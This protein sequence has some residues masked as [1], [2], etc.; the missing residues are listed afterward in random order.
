MH[1]PRF[2]RL[3]RRDA[4]CFQMPCGQGALHESN[5][6]LPPPLYGRELCRRLKGDAATQSIPIIL[7][8]AAGRNA[9]GDVGADD[10][11]DKP[12]DLANLPEMITR[13]AK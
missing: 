2:L 13:W 3:Y 8:S 9:A 12:L 1:L 11:I 6:R 10:Y 4:L 5:R 7:M